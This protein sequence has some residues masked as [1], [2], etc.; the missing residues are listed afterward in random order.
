[1]KS[2]TKKFMLFVVLGA[3]TA[4]GSN[5]YKSYEEKDPA[6]DATVALENNDANKAISILTDALE[7]DPDNVIYK[8]VLAL[9]YA[10][11]AGIDP[12]T[13]AQKMG[14]S[15]SSSSTSSGNGLTSLFS[16]MPDA[17]DANIADVD[18]AVALLYS[19]PTAQRISADILKLAM[20]QV[21]AMTL[22]SKQ[23][24]TDGDGVLSTAELLQMTPES[25]VAILSQLAAAAGIYSG[26]TS[27]STTDKAASEQISKIQ[28]TIQDQPGATD[29]EKLQSYLG[30][31]SA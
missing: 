30:K 10:Q 11:R 13:I 7:A 19:I 20:F 27:T 25:A 31:T 3:F 9:A 23:L 2:L 18:V 15:S 22:R 24:D 6:E 14:T 26:S 4:C 28:T 12:L 21:A 29:Q 8:S 17:T 16:I 1:M 5:P